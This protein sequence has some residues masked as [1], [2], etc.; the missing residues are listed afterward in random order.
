MKYDEEHISMIIK[1]IADGAGR[2]RAVKAAG[3]HYDTFV[4]WMKFDEFK[5]RVLE[6]EGVGMDKIKDLA[7]RGIIEKFNQ[8]WQ[9]AAWWLERN[10]PDE[11]RQRTSTEHSGEMKT[12]M[13]IHIEDSG[14]PIANSE[15]DVQE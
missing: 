12:G 1:A 7:K 14:I 9:A 6:A 10:Y 8:N 5:A 3:I 4:Q 11:Y 15:D 13:T 2:N